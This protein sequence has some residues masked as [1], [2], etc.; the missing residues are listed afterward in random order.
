MLVPKPCHICEEKERD[1]DG[2]GKMERERKREIQRER[3]TEGGRE[4]RSNVRANWK[5][6]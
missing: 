1:W 4:K 3:G 2:R 5:P 6:T